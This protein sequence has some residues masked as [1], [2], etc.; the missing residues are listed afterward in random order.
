MKPSLPQGPLNR[1]LVI[2]LAVAVLGTAGYFGYGLLTDRSCAAGVTEIGNECVGVTDGSYV[3]N[4][5]LGPV[6]ARIKEEN[7]GVAGKNP[8]TVALMIPLISDQQAERREMV[9]QVQGAYLAQYRA[10]REDGKQPPVRLVLANPGREYGQWRHVADQLARSAT[11]GKVNLRAV[12]G[13]N[14]SIANSEAA[15]HYLTA[16]KHIPVVA[17][18]MTA[19][20]IANSAADP[21]H[22]PGL[23]RIAPSNS[24]QADALAAYG[25]GIKP[26]ETLVIEDT[27]EGDNYLSTLRATFAELTKGAPNAPETFESPQDFTQEGNLGNVFDQMVPDICSSAASTLFFA[28]RPVQLRLFLVALGDRKCNKPYTVITGSHASTLMVDQKFESKWDSLTKSAGITVRYTA[29]AHP[30]SWGGSSTEGPGGS[31]GPTAELAALLLADAT[32]QPDRIGPADRRDG[33]II[34]TYDAVTTAVAGI[35]KDVGGSVSMP[36][37]DDVTQSWR[38]LHGG[39]RVDGA[40]GWICLDQYGNPH[41]KAVPIVHLDPAVRGA[42][43]DTVAWPLGHAPDANCSIGAEG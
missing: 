30:D 34:I 24:D 33:R 43:L 20:D 16:E 40:S 41:N 17:G 23:A 38:R 14:I 8:V 27:R 18:P 37:L 29:L 12:T 3:F 26:A 21:R 10:N 31:K 32:K 35:R 7:D 36:S 11:D 15:V 22:Y 2:L 4:D 19:D 25:A 13:I 9:E 39:N 28:G 1:A 42:V 6:T 5:D